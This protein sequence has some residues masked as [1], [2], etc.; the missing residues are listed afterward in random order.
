[1]VAAH[2]VA[3]DLIAAARRLDAAGLNHNASGNASV[4]TAE[5]I[6]VTPTGIPAG[7]LA[8]QDVVLL[9]PDGTPIGGTRRPTSEWQLHVAIM[10]RRPDVT[11]V[12]HTH[13]PEATAAATLRR[14]VPPVHY[15]AA[16]F[17]GPGGALPCADYATYG[18]AALAAAVL[19][20]LGQHGRACLMANHGAVAL[21]GDLDA[22]VA[23][24]IDLEWLC[25]V[26]RRAR[27]LGD[28]MVLAPEEIARVATLFEGYGQPG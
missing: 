25:G 7:A 21:A 24:A 18:S 13:S 3:A 1:M 12:V 17:A 2:L 8:P 5:G 20:T 4:R 19:A 11:A 23:L 27:Q 14:P 9:D 16:R 26:H 10:A 6:L 15:V 22:A 28:P